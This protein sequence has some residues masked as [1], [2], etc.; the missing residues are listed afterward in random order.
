MFQG[1][2][3]KLGGRESFC[4]DSCHRPL[5]GLF[6]GLPLQLAFL[7]T[8][9]SP[10]RLTLKWAI[11][12]WDAYKKAK[13]VHQEMAGCLTQGEEGCQAT[14]L[15]FCA[16]ETE[17]AVV[18]V[19]DRTL[20]ELGDFQCQPAPCSFLSEGREAVRGDKAF[21]GTR[22]TRGYP[23]MFNLQAGTAHW[24]GVLP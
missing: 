20:V 17:A 6:L 3:E 9:F 23:R 19:G 12:A 13:I 14:R 7:V 1:W 16:R 4:E 21:K 22:N 24:V 2:E 10:L 8:N 18:G 15:F 11:A 5:T